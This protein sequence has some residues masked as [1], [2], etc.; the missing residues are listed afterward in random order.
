MGHV[1]WLV[2]ELATG[3]I[4]ASL[5]ITGGTWSLII[6]DA[7]SLTGTLQ[8]ADP[9][10]AALRPRA[11]AEAA[12]CFLAAEWVP[13]DGSDAT[14]LE[15]GPIWTH[16]YDDDTRTLKIGAA[17]VWSYYDHRKVL[18]VLTAAAATLTSTYTGLSL[19]T[20]AKR[21]VELAH[22]HTAGQLP[23]VLP[24]DETGTAAR[25][26]PGYE[27]SWT[28]EQ[29]RA[30]T[31]VDGGPEIAFI[32]RRKASDGRYLEWLMQVG[33]T[34][35]P[36][37]TQPGQD[38]VWDTTVPGGYASRI[39][40]DVDGTRLASRAWV[41]GAGYGESRPMAIADDT[42]LTSGGWPLLEV[43][44][45]GHDTVE[46]ATTLAGLAAQLAVISREPWETWSLQVRAGAI[47]TPGQYRPGHWARVGIAADHPY[48][49]GGDHRGR[50]VRIDGD[51]QG[52]AKVQFQPTLAA[53]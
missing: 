19:G 43:E 32:P 12:R 30:L 26:Y 37:L 20:I 53:T 7:G 51:D 1:Q 25:T 49:P 41:P 3:R 14:I 11:T 24:T 28:G 48:L 6:D 31:Q 22:T 4:T 39:N 44:D 21:L 34:A 23:I 33:T 8:L 50:I 46:D 47:P 13:S 45:T 40:V 36:L 35:A 18:P 17:G 52:N 5:P 29:L 27:L 9:T 15:A 16:S 2:G 42:T 10:V 38:W